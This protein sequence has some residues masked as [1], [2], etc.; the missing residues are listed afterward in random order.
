VDQAQAAL[1]PIIIQ[2][3]ARATAEGDS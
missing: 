3:E 1:Q 2:S